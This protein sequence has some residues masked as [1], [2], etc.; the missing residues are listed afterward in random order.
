MEIK[1]SNPV[2]N[3][4]FWQNVSGTDRMTLEGSLQ[5]IG[6]LLSITLLSAF[7]SALL[8]LNA[9]VDGN[10]MMVISG[11]TSIG[12]MGGFILGLIVMLMRPQNPAALMS[13]YAIFEGTAI[14]AFSIFFETYY[15][16]IALQAAFG[17]VG[18]TATMY[19]M[20]ASRVIR[21]TPTFNKVVSGLVLSIMFI[22]LTSFIL[23]L[24][25]GYNVPFLH[26]SGPFGIAL[27]MFILVVAALT[28]IMDFG[29]IES[30]TRYGAP[31]NMEWYAAF[32]I[33]MSLIWIYIE[34]VRLLSKLR[35]FQD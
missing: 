13:L 11:L 30:G 23:R 7:V 25:S 19:F 17:T 26:S 33:L 27:T 16:G 31:K 6:F 9:M 35:N 24:F 12:F 29:F 18:I 22:Y 34:M 10:G 4:K 28:L 1:S 3:N 21:P 15:S 8:C 14:G 2:L 32:G 5:K 20:Y